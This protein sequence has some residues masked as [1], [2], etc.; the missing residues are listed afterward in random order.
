MASWQQ[1]LHQAALESARRQQEMPPT[2]VITAIDPSEF[3][4]VWAVRY[5]R[6]MLDAGESVAEDISLAATIYERHIIADRR[7]CEDG[8]HALFEFLPPIESM[9]VRADR[10]SGVVAALRRSG[11]HARCTEGTSTYEF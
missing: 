10:M 3:N 9:A 7:N 8:I 11:Y 5:T 6:G 2:W 4:L 1:E